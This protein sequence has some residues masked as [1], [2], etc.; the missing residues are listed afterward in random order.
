M[1]QVAKL[2]IIDN[3]DKYLL[4]YRNAHPIFGNDPDL[5]GGTLEEGESPLE[6]M[7]R[8]VREEIGIE[9]NVN[10]VQK[11]YEG[12]DYAY[13]GNG[14]NESLYTVRLDSRPK[15]RISWEHAGYEWLD[16]ADFLE[17]AKHANDSYMRMVYAVLQ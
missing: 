6:T 15:I 5:A 2:V 1:K 9:I 13:E 8:E 7:V 16:R 11:Q 17:K 3:D 12:S 4:L 14:T 10:S